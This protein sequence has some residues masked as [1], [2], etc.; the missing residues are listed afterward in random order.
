MSAFE[1]RSLSDALFGTREAR[2]AVRTRALLL[3]EAGTRN[4]AKVAAIR[5]GTS[6]AYEPLKNGG[7]FLQ[8]SVV[9]CVDPPPRAW[10]EDLLWHADVTISM[11]RRTIDIDAWLGDGAPP[12]DRF[13]RIDALNTAGGPGQAP[14]NAVAP[15]ATEKVIVR[16]L[17][18][19][20]VRVMYILRG[21]EWLPDA[22]DVPSS[23]D[24]MSDS[25]YEG[26][27]RDGVFRATRRIG[28]GNASVADY[29][30]ASFRGVVGDDVF[31]R[32]IAEVCAS[33]VEKGLAVSERGV[34]D[35][36]SNVRNTS[37]LYRFD[38]DRNAEV[39]DTL[40]RLSPKG[41]AVVRATGRTARAF[42]YGGVHAPPIVVV[43]DDASGNTSTAPRGR[44]LWAF[45]ALDTD[46]SQSLDGYAILYMLDL[47]FKFFFAARDSPSVEACVNAGENVDQRERRRTFFAT[48]FPGDVKKSVRETCRVFD[49]R[50]VTATL[51]VDKLVNA[52]RSM[53]ADR[54]ASIMPSRYDVRTARMARRAELSAPVVE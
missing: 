36:V 28:S 1:L 31:R 7:I 34:M 10:N 22:R 41:S 29:F 20:A 12:T 24:V 15:V 42:L 35:A 17:P 44:K 13:R 50:N 3:L 53:D 32:R 47:P 38:A 9:N 5:N 18:T 40:A 45:T 27:I 48:Y 14:P 26:T 8:F 25:I 21:E 51:D 6:K 54:R 33:L 49:V 23:D 19:R 30:L 16:G 37:T 43:L 4:Y 46:T 52:W 39:L 2:D 11:V